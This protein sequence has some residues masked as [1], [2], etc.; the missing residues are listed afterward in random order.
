LRRLE[1]GIELVVADDGLGFVVDTGPCTYPDRFHF[2][3][4]SM[5]ERA[6]FSGGDLS[7][8]SQAGE[9]T[10]VSVFWPVR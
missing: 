2:G 10:T 3:L 6:A 8:S 7:I 9:G 5:R 4:V 1:N